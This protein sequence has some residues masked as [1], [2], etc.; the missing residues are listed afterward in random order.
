MAELIEWD[1]VTKATY[2]AVNFSGPAREVLGDLSP[3]QRKDFGELTQA[4]SMRFE[5]E[6]RSEM[7]RATLKS[8]ARKR[9]E[10]LPELAQSIR[11]LTKNAYPQAPADV[12]EVLAKDTFVDALDDPTQS[13]R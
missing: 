9:N 12:R 6:N 4:L 11:R 8:M 10:S 1:S 7:Y 3:T 5:T 2:L 13:G